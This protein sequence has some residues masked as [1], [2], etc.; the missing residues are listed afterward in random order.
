MSD[1]DQS[2]THSQ[3]STISLS[4]MTLE[5]PECK[6]E[7]QARSMFK[8]MRLYHASY[9]DRCVCVYTLE[10]FDELIE[11]AKAYPFEWEVTNDFDE[12]ESKSIWGC[13]GCNATFT[14]AITGNK[15][16]QGKCKKEH[17]KGIKD[18]RKEFIKVTEAT[19]KKKEQEKKIPT[20]SKEKWNS[21]IDDA[22]LS[23]SYYHGKLIK[24][25]RK[26]KECGDEEAFATQSVRICPSMGCW[27]W[28]DETHYDKPKLD[29]SETSNLSAEYAKVAFG[30]VEMA[31]QIRIIVDGIDKMLK[32]NEYGYTFIDEVGTVNTPVG[33]NNWQSYCD[34]WMWIYYKHLDTY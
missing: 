30:I 12:K 2:E 9:L 6:K 24:L 3:S 31:H 4:R 27:S 25:I 8:H 20:Y 32:A 7:L 21:M 18:Y 34:S 33:I 26:V 22:L 29:L 10:D 5:C 13:L 28:H 15:H 23:Y 14:S 19:K 1:L 16:C 17:V 11:E